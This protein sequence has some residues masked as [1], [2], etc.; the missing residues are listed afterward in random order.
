MS[1]PTVWRVTASSDGS[2]LD[3]RYRQH[4]DVW[5]MRDAEGRWWPSGYSDRSDME[6]AGFALVPDVHVN[7]CSDGHA[8]TRLP[9]PDE[10]R[11]GATATHDPCCS[12]HNVAMD[13][14]TYRRSHFVQ[15]GICCAAWAAQ[16]REEEG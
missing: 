7:E 16:S 9:L 8:Q 6:R 14:E 5:Q 15:V 3:T 13:C 4:D 10:T 1:D 2:L 12:S 11:Q